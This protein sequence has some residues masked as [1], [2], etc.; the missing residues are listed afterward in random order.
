MA[1]VQAVT[2]VLA[3]LR[4][5]PIVPKTN[6]LLDPR[7]GGVPCPPRL[8]PRS[9]GHSQSVRKSH[10]P[11]AK[12][13]RV[14]TRNP[15]LSI[16]ASNGKASPLC[17][18]ALTSSSRGDGFSRLVEESAAA[19]SSRPIGKPPLV[20]K[21][22][23]RGRQM[24]RRLRAVTWHRSFRGELTFPSGGITIRFE[25]VW[26]LGRSPDTH[27][28]PGRDFAG[29]LSPGRGCA[30]HVGRPEN[31]LPPARFARLHGR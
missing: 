5:R 15:P 1:A 6:C 10:V 12:H 24:R 27:R 4:V 21:R 23:T 7:A 31:P 13:A 25:L 30:L 22:G 19:R 14:R 26:P 9:G 28:Y 3:V 2:Q 8:R 20:A 29:R 16:G 17:P 18:R 11:R